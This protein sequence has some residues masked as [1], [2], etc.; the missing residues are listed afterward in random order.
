MLSFCIGSPRAAAAIDRRGKEGQPMMERRVVNIYGDDI[1]ISI[2]HKSKTVWVVSGF[3][4]ED[5]LK[6]KGRSEKAAVEN[7][8]KTAELRM[9]R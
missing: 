8:V 2:N 7:W 5:S 1:E 3:I 4:M 9:R 6:V